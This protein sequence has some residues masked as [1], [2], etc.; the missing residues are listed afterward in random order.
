MSLAE[1]GLPDRRPDRRADPRARAAIS[2]AQARE[3]AVELLERVGIPRA[4]RARA[5]LPARVLGR[6]APAR[7]DRDG[8]VVRP[9]LLIA[10]EPTTALDVTIQAQILREIRELREET[11]RGGHPRHPRPRRGR[12]HRR[13]RARSCTPGGSSSRARSTRSSTTRSTPTRGG[14]WARS[15]GSTAT[16]SRAAAGDPGAAAVAAA[17]R[18]QGCHFRPRCPHAFDEC[19]EVPAARGARAGDAGAPRPLLARRVEREARRCA[20]SSRA[21]SGSR[22]RQEAWRRERRQRRRTARC[23]R[24]STSGLLPDRARDL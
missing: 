24:S 17:D 22:P 4:A 20:R 14:C 6:H 21:R 3:R 15:R 16:A 5:L 7:D 12:R 23:S 19:A 11:R 1:P 2:K 9:E 18:P 13:P 8:A 10:D